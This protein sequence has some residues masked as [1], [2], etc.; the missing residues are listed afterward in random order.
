MNL[1]YSCPAQR[2]EEPFAKLINGLE[3]HYGTPKPPALSNPLDFIIWE[4][5]GYLVDDERRAVAFAALR[6]E[7]GLKPAQTSAAPI[8]QLIAIATLGGIHPDPRARR[9]KE[10]ALIVM[11]EFEGDFGTVLKLSKPAA[12]RALKNFP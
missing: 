11:S 7:V 6:E 4:S 12:I 2:N 10:I 5:I 8:K 1:D 3:S 9:L